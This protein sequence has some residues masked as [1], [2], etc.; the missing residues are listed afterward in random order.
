[1]TT[2]VQRPAPDCA[3]L[4]VKDDTVAV[5]E[6]LGEA[7]SILLPRPSAPSAASVPS[8][9]ETPAVTKDFIVPPRRGAVVYAVDPRA[10]LTARRTVSASASTS[11]GST[12]ALAV[13]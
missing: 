13:T 2:P 3:G 7:D 9:A 5:A 1:M 6:E 10:E 4:T 8:T 11:L 12:T